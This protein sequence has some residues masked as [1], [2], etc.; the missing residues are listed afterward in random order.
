MIVHRM[1]KIFCY[2]NNECRHPLRSRSQHDF[3]HSVYACDIIL[4]RGTAVPLRQCHGVFIGGFILFSV[5][6]FR[7]IVIGRC[8]S[9]VDNNILFI[10]RF[11]RDL[12]FLSTICKQYVFIADSK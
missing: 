7:P 2:I 12:I 5:D 4:Y 10:Y 1:I 8:N 6:I 3:D 11:I 9:I